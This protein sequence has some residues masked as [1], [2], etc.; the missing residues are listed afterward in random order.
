MSLL[1]PGSNANRFAFDGKF[2]EPSVGRKANVFAF[3]RV[4]RGR[5][6]AAPAEENPGER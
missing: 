6:E 5:G 1:F 3:R 4:F 2:S